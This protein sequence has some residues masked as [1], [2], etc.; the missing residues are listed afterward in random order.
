MTQSI[1]SGDYIVF[2]EVC[3]FQDKTTANYKAYCS[4][5]KIRCY[6]VSGFSL[7]PRDSARYSSYSEEVPKWKTQDGELLELRQMS[8]YH[9][10]NALRF[11]KRKF[12]STED[13]SQ[14]ARLACYIIAFQNLKK[15][16][17]AQQ[18]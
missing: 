5:G 16:R 13:E 7:D 6:S 11:C 15:L 18:D 8:S 12:V 4:D 1:L 2:G 3:E 14:K 10:L 9:R 17:K